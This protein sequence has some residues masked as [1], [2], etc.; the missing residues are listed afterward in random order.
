MSATSSPV[1]LWNLIG[2]LEENQNTVLFSDNFTGSAIKR[3][4]ILTHSH[5][6]MKA[7]LPL[8]TY[9]CQT[10]LTSY[11]GRHANQFHS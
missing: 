7:V 6:N 5:F 10:Y 4:D 9:I 8:T 11:A 1:K 2:F 3:A